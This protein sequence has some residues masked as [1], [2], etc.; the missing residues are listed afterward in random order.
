MNDNQPDGMTSADVE[1]REFLL[2]AFRDVVAETS[3]SLEGESAEAQS[4]WLGARAFCVGALLTRENASGA[5][6]ACGEALEQLPDDLTAAE[7]REVVLG[8]LRDLVAD[9]ERT[10]SGQPN[11]QAS[12]TAEAVGQDA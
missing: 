11:A 5:L 1:A 8:L 2:L 7:C 4:V 10:S 6:R 12:A 3:R 9:L